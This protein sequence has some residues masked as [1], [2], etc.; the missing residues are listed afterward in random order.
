MTTALSMPTHSFVFDVVM[1][2]RGVKYAKLVK[3]EQR[4][5]MAICMAVRGKE[6]SVTKGLP[7][8]P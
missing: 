8:S 4:P 3:N 1:K 7:V 5:A 6:R 2:T